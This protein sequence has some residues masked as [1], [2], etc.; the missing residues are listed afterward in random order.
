MISRR[1]LQRVFDAEGKPGFVVRVG[2]NGQ[3][4]ETPDAAQD[5]D[6]TAADGLPATGCPLAE[7]AAETPGADPEQC[8]D[9]APVAAPETGADVNERGPHKALTGCRFIKVRAKG[10]EAIEKGWQETRNYAAG[11]PE[12]LQHLAMGGN[13]GVMPASGICILDADE[14]PRMME[15]LEPFLDTFT[16]RTG[17]DGVKFHF[18]FRCDGLEG[19]VPFYDLEDGTHLG[20]VY[21]SGAKAYCVGPGSLHPSGRRYEVV[22]DLPLKEIPFEV[23]EREFLAK[24]KS[25]R[26]AAAMPVRRPPEAV[27]MGGTI[28][29]QLGLRCEEFLAPLKPQVSGEEIIGEHPVHGSST[30]T[31]LAINP[32]KNSWVCRRCNSGGGPLEAL[33]VA[34]GLIRCDEA[35]PDCLDG[36]WQEVFDLLRKHGHNVISRLDTKRGIV[37]QKSKNEIPDAEVRATLGT[38]A[39]AL[40]VTGVPEDDVLARVATINGSKRVKAPVPDAEVLTIVE[41]AYQALTPDEAFRRTEI[42]RKTPPELEAAAEDLL[43]EG[44][45]L[46]YFRDVYGGMHSGDVP[47]L[48]SIL[49]GAAVQSAINTMGIQPA[50]NGPSGAGKTSGAK[51]ALHL[52]PPELVFKTSL[53]SKALFYDERLRPGCIIFSDD[54]TLAFDILD[55]IKR[56]M[57]NFQ[58]PTEHLT[59]DRGAN[60]EN[61]ARALVIPPRQMFLFTAVGDT[62]DDQ[63]NDRQYMISVEQTPDTEREFDEFLKARVATGREEYPVTDDVLVCREILRTVRAHLF[64]VRVPFAHAVRFTDLSKKRNM[65]SFFDYVMASAILNFRRRPQG[66]T[67]GDEENVITLTATVEDFEAAREIFRA[68][69]DTRAYDLNKEERALLDWIIERSDGIGIAEPDIVRDYRTRGGKALSRAKVLRLLHGRADQASRGGLLAKVPGMYSEQRILEIGERSRRA[70]NVIFAPSVARSQLRDYEEWVRLESGPAGDPR[71]PDVIQ[72]VDRYISTGERS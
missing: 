31:N 34:E 4:N 21:G 62:G 9:A 23:L 52:M 66:H 65:G 26:S 50:L 5:I 61:R 22:R 70:V 24:V 6:S 68:N 20:E 16:V 64:R 55:T 33:A 12:L 15:L 59:V 18:Y 67:P 56:A 43:Q 40:R 1:E 32:T 29:D 7:G 48:D 25:S 11:D 58:E 28:S 46:E 63:L 38:I 36:K 35:G 14:A 30:G 37:L 17:G 51:A 41:E 53:S 2:Q 27:S 44:R 10:K 69:E 47:V 71:D 42:A 8:P 57:S 49:C 39:R 54:T 60:S 13:Y 3:Q 45:V 72:S 19:K